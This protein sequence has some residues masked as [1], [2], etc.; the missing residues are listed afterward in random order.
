MVWAL[1]L[2]KEGNKYVQAEPLPW[3][4]QVRRFHACMAALDAFLATD[5]PM[6]TNGETLFQGPIA[7]ALSHVG[8]INLLRRM[9]GSH[10]RGENYTKATI[11]SGRLGPDQ[12][13][14]DPKYEFD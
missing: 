3:D 12:K 11:E 9:F 4:E 5:E 14:P 1:S 7:D 2:A 10:V 8:Q 13:P 6:A